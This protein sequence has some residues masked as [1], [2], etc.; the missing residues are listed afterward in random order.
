MEKWTKA[1]RWT[2]TWVESVGNRVCAI[3]DPCVVIF[4]VVDK[5][6]PTAVC[7]RITDDDARVHYTHPRHVRLVEPWDVDRV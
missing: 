4:G 5:V 2:S 1:R 3:V 7:M 6:Y